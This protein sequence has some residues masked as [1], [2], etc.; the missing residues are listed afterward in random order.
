[1]NIIVIIKAF[2]IVHRQIIGDV[3]GW[4][5]SCLSIYFYF[6]PIVPIFSLLKGETSYKNLP[7]FLFICTIINCLLWTTYALIVDRLQLY[8]TCGTGELLS[9]IWI[10]I[11]IA[12]SSKRKIFPPMILCIGLILFVESFS[13]FCYYYLT[14]EIIGIAA[15]AMKIIMYA[16]PCEK[17]IK[18]FQ[19]KNYQLIPIFSSIGI[20]ASSIGWVVYSLCVNDINVLIP[21][22]TGIGFGLFQIT[23]YLIFYC[24][25]ENNIKNKKKDKNKSI[26]KKKK[27]EKK[28]MNENESEEKKD[29]FVESEGN[30]SDGNIENI[31]SSKISLGNGDSTRISGIGLSRS[32]ESYIYDTRKQI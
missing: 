20:V 4:I 23:I 12:F 26:K 24:R 21:N 5:A 18:V 8:I 28:E 13:L 6:S 16:A 14:S 11:Y 3:S 2:I 29:K 17:L 22:L 32:E 1:M 25:K 27:E 10:T 19:N 9:L 7:I 31:D 15:L 30:N